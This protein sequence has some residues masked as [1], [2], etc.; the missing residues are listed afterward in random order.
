[1]IEIKIDQFDIV[2]HNDG[3]NGFIDVDL[4]SEDKKFVTLYLSECVA[5]DLYEALR[6]ILD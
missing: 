3:Q 2:V 5:S 1:M 4:M 6:E